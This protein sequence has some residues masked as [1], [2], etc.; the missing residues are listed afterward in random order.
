[1]STRRLISVELVLF[2]VFSILITFTTLFKFKTLFTQDDNE[3]GVWY[4]RSMLFRGFSSQ[5]LIELMTVLSSPR[6][7]T[8]EVIFCENVKYLVKN[9]FWQYGEFISEDVGA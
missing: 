7:F 6:P 4:S 5:Y 2:P 8:A 1:M 3:Q 9:E